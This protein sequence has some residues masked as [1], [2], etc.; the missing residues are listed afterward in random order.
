[1]N[2]EK[3][4]DMKNIYYYSHIF[5]LYHIDILNSAKPQVHEDKLALSY[6]PHQMEEIPDLWDRHWRFWQQPRNKSNKRREQFNKR[7]H[8][9]L[10]KN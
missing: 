7:P 5:H 1:M 10:T 8:F 6:H 4:D 2:K 9:M 3:G